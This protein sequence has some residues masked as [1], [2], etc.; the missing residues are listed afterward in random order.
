MR[1]A[2]LLAA[3][4]AAAPSVAHAAACPGYDFDLGSATGPSMASGNTCGRGNDATASCG[5]QARSEDVV[6]LW[7]APASGSFT[8]DLGG[9]NYDTVLYVQNSTTCQELVCNDDSIG[10]Q[11]SVT[12]NV[13]QGNSYIL[14]VDGYSTAA[15]GNFILNSTSCTIDSDGDGVCDQFDR[16]Y[17]DDSSGDTDGDGICDD[18]DMNLQVTPIT[19]GQSFDMRVS[20]APPGAHL[21]FMASARTGR[22]CHPQ[23]FPCLDLGSPPIVIGDAYANA[24]GVATYTRNAPAVL[25][26]NIYI[27]A[28]WVSVGGGGI[29]NRVQP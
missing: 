8:F 23:G 10:L 27:Q 17:G 21:F 1:S 14:N 26:N 20:N 4:I 12:L 24:N 2:P 9:S 5:G 13:T 15:C 29:T 11:S 19:A 18:S 6:Y 16:C 7:T 3:L 22:V 25:P 28:W